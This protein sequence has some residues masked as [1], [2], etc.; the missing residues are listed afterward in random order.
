MHAN[1]VP[2]DVKHA[3][4]KHIVRIVGIHF[5]WSQIFAKNARIIANT[6]ILK[7]ENAFSAI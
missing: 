6:V 1:I 5:T 3:I 7:M 4:R 2:M